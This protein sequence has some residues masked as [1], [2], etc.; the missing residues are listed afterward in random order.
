MNC[1]FLHTINLSSC[2][3]LQRDIKRL[4]E[5]HEEI[6]TLKERLGINVKNRKIPPCQK[7]ADRRYP[8]CPTSLLI[9]FKSIRKSLKYDTFP[10]R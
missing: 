3:T 5:G 8:N 7:F 6:K 10:H 2:R 9:N 1:Q 4:F